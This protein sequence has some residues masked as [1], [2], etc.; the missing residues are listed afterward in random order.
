MEPEARALHLV[1]NK[2]EHSYLKVHEIV[3]PRRR[4]KSVPD[5]WTDRLAYPVQREMFEAMTLHVFRLARAAMI[6][7]SL[8][9][10]REELRRDKANPK[11]KRVSMRLDAWC[12]AWKR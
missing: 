4:E 5:L 9:M 2:L 7:L 8:G 12:D 11:A 3:V 1:R 10:H 6:Y